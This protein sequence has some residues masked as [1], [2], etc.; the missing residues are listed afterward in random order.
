MQGRITESVKV[1]QKNINKRLATLHSTS[2]ICKPHNRQHLHLLSIGM[3]YSIY[4]TFSFDQW[5]YNWPTSSGLNIP[6]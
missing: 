4:L 5:M 6:A 3:M 1:R 2:S